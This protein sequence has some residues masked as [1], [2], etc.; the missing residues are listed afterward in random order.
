MMDK[1]NTPM[2]YVENL[3]KAMGAWR[4][5]NKDKRAFILLSMSEY[6]GS[7]DSKRSLSIYS[8]GTDV[9]LTN[10]LYGMIMRNEDFRR[11]MSAAVH[12]VVKHELKE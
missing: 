8:E 9:Q 12:L 11:N 3:G 1:K 6:T 10:L 4:D 7:S 2:S 5:E